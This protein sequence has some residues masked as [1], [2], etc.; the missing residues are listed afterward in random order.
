MRKGTC[1]PT[2]NRH[3][4]PQNTDGYVEVGGSVHLLTCPGCNDDDPD[5]KPLQTGRSLYFFF[6][7][8]RKLTFDTEEVTTR[9]R[10]FICGKTGMKD[11]IMHNW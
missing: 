2:Q 4:Q 11:K 8:E 9:S 3:Y 7:T 6:S 5:N 10:E 1:Q